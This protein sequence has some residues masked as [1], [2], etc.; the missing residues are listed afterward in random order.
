MVSMYA[1]A[2]YRIVP[3]P[4]WIAFRLLKLSV[5]GV[6]GSGLLKAVCAGVWL[7]KLC[8]RLPHPQR[9]FGGQY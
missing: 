4:A 9:H 3:T 1:H 7:P 2:N 5:L 6:V 8:E